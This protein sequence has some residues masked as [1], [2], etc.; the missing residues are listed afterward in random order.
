MKTRWNSQYNTICKVLEISHTTLNDILRNVGRADLVLTSRNIIILQE[1]AS[2]FALFAEA[3]TRT[4]AENSASI[5]LVSPSILSIYFDLEQEQGKCKYLG[6]LCRI[7][8]ISLHER[9]GGLLE[10]CGIFPDNDMRIKK[11]STSDLYKDDIYLIT[12]FLDGRFKIQWISTSTLSTTSKERIANMIK[13]LVLKAALQLHGNTNNTSY[14]V[15]ESSINE[16][17]LVNDNTLTCINLPGFKRKQL[18]S[19]YEGERTPM[20]KTRSCLSEAIESEISSFENEMINDAGLIFVKKIT[21]PYLYL[22][23]TRV[24]CIPATSAPVERVFSASGI[25]MRPHRSRL[26]SNVL[27]MLTLLKCNRQLL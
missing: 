15:L 7:L 14:S 4:Q 25:F 8:L 3:T 26:S 1:F 24:L 16:I 22:L 12:P 10:R 17:D 11:R 2:I 27:S 20:K 19:N 23:A 18:F 13:T 6:L 5:S 9:F 21:Y